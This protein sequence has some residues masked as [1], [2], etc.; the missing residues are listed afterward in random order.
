MITYDGVIQP[1]QENIDDFYSEVVGWTHQCWQ[2]YFLENTIDLDEFKR[3]LNVDNIDY[4][5]FMID[6]AERLDTENFKLYI[7]RVIDLIYTD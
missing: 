1:N 3:R 6:N 7:Q 4:R 5:Q 2:I